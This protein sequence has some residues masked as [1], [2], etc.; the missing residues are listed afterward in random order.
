MSLFSWCGG[1]HLDFEVSQ[2]WVW[3]HSWVRIHSCVTIH[4]LLKVVRLGTHYITPICNSFFICK[5]GKSILLES[6]KVKVLVTQLCDSVASWTVACQAP[7]SIEFSRQQYWSG[8]PFPSPWD[9]PNPGSNP[10]FLHAGRFF[11]TWGF[12]EGLK[13]SSRASGAFLV[14]SVEL[15]FLS[16]SY[17][18]CLSDHW[19]CQYLMIT[20]YCKSTIW[21]SEKEERS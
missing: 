11:T 12:V 19:S 6:W 16:P 8:L 17:L 3:I 20:F 10:G 7:L 9:L 1:S 14:L 2:A 13:L 4:S 15:L 5:R 18:C 21:G